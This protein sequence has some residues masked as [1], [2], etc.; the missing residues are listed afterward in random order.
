MTPVRHILCPIDF[1][2]F[3]SASLHHAARLA[4][5][6]GAQLHGLH[7]VQSLPTMWHLPPRLEPLAGIPMVR[8]H[9]EIDRVLAAA[10]ECGVAT[11]S[12]V[13]EG[14]AAA[15]ILDHAKRHHIDLIVMGTHG[16]SGLRRLV[17]GSVAEAVVRKAPCPV[18]T[19]RPSEAPVSDGAPF[20]RV[21]CPVD[22]SPTSNAA[23]AH[24]LA[25][26]PSMEAYVTI[27]HVVEAY[28]P[29][30]LL[31]QSHWSDEAYAQALGDHA[32]QRL[33][34]VAIPPDVQAR[35]LA[36]T[37]LAT[38]DVSQEILREAYDINADLIVIGVHRRSAVEAS[39]F[40]SHANDIIR[41]AGCPVMTFTPGAAGTVE[42]RDVRE[43]LAGI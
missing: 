27:L 20:R 13:A 23:V 6:H 9:D 36:R 42:P 18:M 26:A 11:M 24:A 33:Q 2:E 12:H 15:H 17:L 8:L 30:L 40:G 38:G 1:S 28:Y 34:D 19:V 4:C 21:L 3:S 39:L 43:L 10:R 16:R 25:L 14:G 32:R 31:Q 41:H 5:W 29:G 37:V 7:V 22:F 35:G